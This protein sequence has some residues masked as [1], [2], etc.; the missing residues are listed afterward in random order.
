M[1]PYQI[2]NKTCKLTFNCNGETFTRDFENVKF[3]SNI[4]Y[5]EHPFIPF[6]IEKERSMN[7][8]IELTQQLDENM[9]GAI[10]NVKDMDDYN[11]FGLTFNIQ[12]QARKHKKKRIN[13]KWLKRYG[14]RCYTVIVPYAKCLGQDDNKVYF[15]AFPE[16]GWIK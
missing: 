5:E 14:T 11:D 12:V 2:I 7:C 16:R 6:R 15:E 3:E 4:T 9:I 13:K 10:T 1:N 8:N